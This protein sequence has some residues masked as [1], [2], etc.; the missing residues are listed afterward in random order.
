[1]L[2][3][4]HEQISEYFVNA[5]ISRTLGLT[6]SFDAEE[7]AHLSMPYQPSVDNVANGIH[8]G[9]MAMLLDSAGWCASAA[10]HPGVWVATAQLSVHFLQHAAACDL[11]AEGWVVRDGKR[12]SIV[13]MKVADARDGTLY[14][15]GSATMTVLDIPIGK[16]ASPAVREE[17]LAFPVAQ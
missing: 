11:H 15:I 6:I 8:G 12:L 10:R 3:E 2:T 16:L 1:M 5:P 13:E 7:N 17:S 14:A 4:W 9:V